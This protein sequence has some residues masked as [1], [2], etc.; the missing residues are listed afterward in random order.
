MF[1]GDVIIGDSHGCRFRIAVFT[2][3]GDFLQEFHCPY[4]EI[5][6][7]FGLKITSDGFIVTLAKINHHVLVLNPLYLT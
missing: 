2:R 4:V 7:C 3:T 1:I 6:R 5:S